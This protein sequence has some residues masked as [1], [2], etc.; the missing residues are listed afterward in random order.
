M[1]VDSRPNELVEMNLEMVR[2]M[3][4]VNSVEFT[5]KPEG[6]QTKVTWEM[7]GHNSF[8]S[9]AFSLFFNM[10]KMVGGE[11]EKGLLDMKVMAEQSHK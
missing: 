2:P 10:D 1:I 6:D 3:K 9:K 7:T 4:A 8:V 11:F 5:F